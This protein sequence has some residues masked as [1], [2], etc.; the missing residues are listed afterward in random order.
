MTVQLSKARPLRGARGAGT[1]WGHQRSLNRPECWEQTAFL[2]INTAFQLV[3]TL[4][5]IP[6]SIVWFV[7]G[8][9]RLPLLLVLLVF[10]VIWIILMGIILILSALSRAV[11]AVRPLCFICALPFLVIGHFMVTISPVPTPADAPDVAMKWEF[12][13]KF[14]HG[15]ESLQKQADETDAML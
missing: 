3:A 8:I 10:D 5:Y 15:W 6:L 13:E 1:G 11:P 14:P 12:L 4:L 9:A 7:C 2:V